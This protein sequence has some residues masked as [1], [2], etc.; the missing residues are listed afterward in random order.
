MSKEFICKGC[1]EKYKNDMQSS[2]VG[3]CYVCN[4]F[5]MKK[6]LTDLEAKLTEKENEIFDLRHQQIVDKYKPAFCELA[7]RDCKVFG[8]LKEKEKETE[9]LYNRLNS[10]QKFYEMGLEKDYKEYLSRINKLEKQC[11]KDKIDFAV[12]LLL[13]VQF[14]V[15]KLRGIVKGGRFFINS[16]DYMSYIDQQIKEL[17]EMK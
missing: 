15:M 5:Y 16:K 13:K 14:D 17:K 1:K 12:K 6:Y 3:Y 8:E 11:D 2:N 4:E 10:K 7:G 9:N